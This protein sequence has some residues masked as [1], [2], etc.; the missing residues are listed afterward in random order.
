VRS[1]SPAAGAMNVAINTAIT[2]EFL[3]EMNAATINETTF[4]LNNGVTGAVA[5][6]AVNRVATFTP[7]GN[8]AYDT[9]YTAT[10][11]TGVR[12]LAGTGMEQDFAWSFTTGAAPDTTPPLVSSTTPSAGAVR[13]PINTSV[14]AVFSEALVAA[15]INGTTFTLSSGTAAT[16]T[17]TYDSTNR[18]AA[19]A[20]ATSLEANTTYTATIAAGVKD[21]SGNAMANDYVW[22]FATGSAPDATPPSVSG[23]SPLNAAVDVPVTTNITATFSEEMDSSTLSQLVFIVADQNGNSVSGG[24]S[25]AGTAAVFTPS[26]ILS[27]GTPFTVKITTGAKDLAGNALANDFTWSFT[28]RTVSQLPGPTLKQADFSTAREAATIVSA[29]FGAEALM[30]AQFSAV[31]ALGQNS[32]PAGFAPGLSGGIGG[33]I[34]GLDPTLAS[35][36]QSMK[37]LSRSAIIQGALR[38]AGVLRAQRA[39]AVDTTVTTEFCSNADGRVGIAGTNNYD[40][41]VNPTVA[42][43]YDLTFTNCRDDVEFTQ[44]DGLLHI[45]GVQSTDTDA[46]TS[47]LTA[48]NLAENKF[49]SAAFDVMTQRSVLNGSF[50]ND[51]QVNTMARTASGSFAVT[52]PAGT[53]PEKVTTL[54]FTGLVQA[55]SVTHNADS[56]DT[57]ATTSTGTLTLGVVQGGTGTLQLTLGIGLEDRMQTMNDSAGTR[58]D[59]INGTVDA[60]WTIGPGC[61]TGSLTFFTDMASPRIFTSAAG[62]CPV[63]GAVLVNNGAITYGS[64]IVVTVSNGDMQS[65]TD[66]TAL[67]QAGAVCLP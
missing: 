6:D 22:S 67:A 47:R 50:S 62:L 43:A 56:T 7:S 2:A 24:V 14:T 63:S 32:L 34:A 13:V 9:L 8:L 61:K 54:G 37:S 21:L 1:T 26:G 5:Y 53:G 42:F 10:L 23:T 36:V 46:G 64:P 48:N 45:E 66:C 57:T 11:T 33:D 60:A 51:N 30:D 15:T 59:W 35:I 41:A 40:E 12:E 44:L 55:G 20:P 4:T 29:F 39:T 28:T 58:K 27:Y 19:F 31:M 65:F 25:S 16:G 38:R 52:T 3:K 17:V 49:S 18:V